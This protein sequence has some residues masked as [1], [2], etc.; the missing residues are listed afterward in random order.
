MKTTKGRTVVSILLALV[1]VFTATVAIYLSFTYRDAEPMLLTQP[2]SARHRVEELM[3]A[4]SGAD[5]EKV[6]KLLYG[7]PELGLDR[8]AADE[9]GVLVWD[10]FTKSISYELVGDSYLTDKGLAQKIRIIGLDL[11]SIAEFVQANAETMLN[12]QVEEAEDRDVFFDENDAYKKEFITEILCSAATR[13]LE[14]GARE[15]TVE[16]TLY[17][18]YEDGKW[19]VMPDS[20]L[21]DAIS[22][23]I[24][25]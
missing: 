21:L 5:F 13:A 6:S 10:A 1:A 15:R 23:G 18:T 20:E 2:E 16:L 4:V 3:D 19:W 22:G 25:Y 14:E 24:L 9:V 7:H 17:M 12:T 11:D 8:V